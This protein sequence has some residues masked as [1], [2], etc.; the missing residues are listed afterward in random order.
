MEAAAPAVQADSRLNDAID[1][2]RPI[3]AWSP[4]NSER[5]ASGR[6]GA[7]YWQQRVDYDIHARLDEP[8]RTITGRAA[9]TYHNHSPDA[10]N[11]LW[12]EV[13]QNR[14]RPDALS[15]RIV[16]AGE[17][18][19]VSLDALREIRQVRA[20]PLGM[21]IGDVSDGD[22]N[23]S[24]TV[25]GTF[26]RAPLRHA[27]LPGGSVTLALTWSYVVPSRPIAKSRSGWEALADGEAV[28]QIGEWY[29]RAVAYT[30]YGGW[31]LQ[32]IVDLGEFTLDFGDFRVALTVPG[33]HVVSATGELRNPEGVLSAR[34]RERLACT[35]VGRQ[36][37][38]VTA[39]EASA[40]RAATAGADRT[41]IFEAHDVRDFAWASSRRYI[42]TVKAVKVDGRAEPVRAAVFYPPEAAPLWGRFGV[43]GIEQAL[44]VYG[45]AAFPYPYPVIQA[46]YGPTEGMEYPMLAFSAYA[47]D[48]ADGKSYSLDRKH[49]FLWVLIHEVGHNWFP[50]VV[51]SDERRWGWM[52]EGLNSFVEH[53]AMLGWSAIFDDHLGDP[54]Q[55]S[56]DVLGRPQ[57]P[58]MTP[59]DLMPDDFSFQYRKTTAALLVLREAVLGRE[60]FDRAF[61]EYGRA[62]SFKRPPSGGLLPHDGAGVGGGSLLVLAGLVLRHRAGGPDARLRYASDAHA[63]RSRRRATGN[64]PADAFDYRAGGCP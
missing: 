26:L 38:V 33:D 25:E 63:R 16:T 3:A 41:W 22:G 24:W 23:L 61:A 55:L 39:A 44:V 30:D 64:R 6:P 46:A 2:F 40:K 15:E 8:S 10:L 37:D 20:Q 43:A 12:F 51:D 5:L 4:P 14:Y 53:R 58:I 27:L 29:P 21:T 7:T 11:T 48:G 28:F 32:P 54:R 13:V 35:P 18:E 59:S 9:V 57:A 50:M 45:H 47:P 36:V 34:E 19:K 31:R 17:S 62:W 56:R 60:R 49:E 1:R 52:D 42:E